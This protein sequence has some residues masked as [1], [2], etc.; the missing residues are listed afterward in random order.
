MIAAGK[1]VYSKRWHR[2]Y[3]P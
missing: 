1:T 2:H 3:C